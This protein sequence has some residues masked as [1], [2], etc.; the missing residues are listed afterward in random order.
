MAREIGKVNVA[1]L[2][3]N[4]YKVLGIGINTN[5]NTGGMFSVNYLTLSQAKSNITNLILTRKGERVAQPEFG[6]DIWKILFEPII[7]DEIDILVEK[8]IAEAVSTWLPYIEINEIVL[9]YDDISKDS[10]KFGVEINFGLKENPNLKES[11]K[12]N[13]NN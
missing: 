12:I 7:D 2:A 11:V 9:D 4:N 5:S 8:Y 10:H 6:C 3:E 1:D 13:V